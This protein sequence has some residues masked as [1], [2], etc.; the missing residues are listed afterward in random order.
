[1]LVVRML[2][3]LEVERDGVSQQIGSPKQ[4]LLLALLAAQRGPISRDRLVGALWAEDPPASATATLMG[5]VSRLRAALGSH[6][7]VGRAEGYT[8]H[9]DYVDAGEFESLLDRTED[10]RSLES[11]L[12]LWRG[13][14][15]GE[16][17]DHPSLLPEVR[18]LGNLR[19]QARLDLATALLAEHE[20]TRPISMLEVLV[21]EE[22]FR[23]DVWLQLIRALLAAGRSA[24][25]VLAAHRCR[26]QLAEIGLDPG[27]RLA[28]AE[29]DALQ[30][31]TTSTPSATQAEIRPIRYARNGGVH[32]AYQVVGGGPIDLVCASYGSV[33]IDSIWDSELFATYVTRLAASCRVV[34]YDT[35]GVGLSDPIDVSAP[36]SINEQSDDLRAIIEASGA[37]RPVIVGVGDGGPTAIRYAY[38]HPHELIGLVLINTF[39]RLIEAPDYPGVTQDQFDA[40]LH[41]S[42][43]PDTTRDTSLVLRNHAPSVASDPT[44]RRWWERAGRRGA[45]PATATALWRVRYGADVRELL[46]AIDTPSL[47]LHRRGTRVVP[48][49]FGIYLAQHLP[50]VRLLELD[51]DDQP[52]FTG[53]PDTIAD[54]IT[55]FANGLAAR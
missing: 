38:D 36:P 31:R 30:Q 51:G 5:Y 2:G 19:V 22:P 27:P 41:M 50:D 42:T 7:I 49:A 16:L 29:S 13:D 9:A 32:L 39:A 46:D 28:E 10:R 15:F 48:A 25:A 21:A 1:V 8:L 45:S 23:E 54:A 18:R 35:R 14:A 20:T 34:L 3:P 11:A 26:R 12:T 53:D 44:F 40:T 17:S 6:A 4:R 43:D 33:S 52:P 24:D 55:D 47:V 37:D